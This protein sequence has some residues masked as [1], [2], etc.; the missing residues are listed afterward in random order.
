MKKK[1]AKCLKCGKRLKHL[2][3]HRKKLYCNSTCR[4]GRWAIA[5]RAEAKK[6]MED[7][8]DSPKPKAVKKKK[9][10]KKAEVKELKKHFSNEVEVFPKSLPKKEAKV[11]GMPVRMEGESAIDF[12]QRKNDFKRSQLK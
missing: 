11:V 10:S 1:P 3:G 6:A 8:D 12:A 2:A 4:S 7:A 9:L 5:A